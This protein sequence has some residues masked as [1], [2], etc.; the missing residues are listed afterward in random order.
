MGRGEMPKPKS[1]F[2]ASELKEFKE[3]LNRRK[4]EISGNMREIG[5]KTL[6]KNPGA[7]SGDIS[8]LP[9]HM[10]DVGSNV[11]E[12]DMNLS[13][14]ENEAQELEEIEEALM[15][16]QKGEFGMC[17]VCRRAIGKQRLKAIPYAR[18]CIQCKRKEEGA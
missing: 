12:H 18:L 4:A 13:L 17:E 7:E 15:K 2:S 10:A 6:G 1:P 14:V 11:F 9:M 16:M 3:L 8:T 5:K